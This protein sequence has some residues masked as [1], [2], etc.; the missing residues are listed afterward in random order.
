M[1]SPAQRSVHTGI[2]FPCVWLLPVPLVQHEALRVSGHSEVTDPG[3][4]RAAFNSRGSLGPPGASPVPVAPSVGE[5]PSDEALLVNG[6]KVPPGN[7]PVCQVLVKTEEEQGPRAQG[8]DEKTPEE[9]EGWGRKVVSREEVLSC[10]PSRE[11]WSLLGLQTSVLSQCCCYLLS[12][13]VRDLVLSGARRPGEQTRC[14]PPC[15]HPCCKVSSCLA[16]MGAD[17]GQFQAAACGQQPVPGQPRSQDGRPERGGVRPGAVAAVEVLAQPAAVVEPPVCPR[18]A[19]QRRARH[20]VC[21][22]NFPRNY[23]P[24]YSI[25]VCRSGDLST[26][27]AA[28]EPRGDGAAAPSLALRPGRSAPLRSTAP[29]RADRERRGALRTARGPLQPPPGS[30]HP[31][32]GPPRSRLRRFPRPASQLSYQ[33]RPLPRGVPALFGYELFYGGTLNTDIYEERMYGQFLWFL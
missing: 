33:R 24:Q 15:R 9:G 17:R 21:F 25:M 10:K 7:P 3:L 4:G 26:V 23:I 13:V 32:Q 31:V 16:E 14:V 8:L 18:P 2:H 22:L 27:R 6:H 20:Q 5:I 29:R 1:G 11:R 12:L 19:T 28:P 30:R